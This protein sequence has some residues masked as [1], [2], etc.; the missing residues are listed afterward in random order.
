MVEQTKTKPWKVGINA[1][2]IAW[3]KEFGIDPATNYGNWIFA[4]VNAGVY[5]SSALFGCWLSDPLNNFFGRRGCVLFAAVFSFTSSLGASVTQTWGQLLL[6]RCLLGT[7][8]TF[9]IT[10]PSASLIEASNIPLLGVGM[11]IKASGT[12]YSRTFYFLFGTGSRRACLGVSTSFLL[13]FYPQ[14]NSSAVEWSY[15]N[16]GLI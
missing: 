2:N 9:L 16:S 7:R 6:C 11:G 5:F 3:P 4:I 14:S 8:V 10:L 13:L 1:A 15:T 12:Y